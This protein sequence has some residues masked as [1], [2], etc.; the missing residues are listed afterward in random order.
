M[1]NFFN[2]RYHVTPAATGGFS[3]PAKLRFGKARLSQSITGETQQPPNRHQ[4]EAAGYLLFNNSSFTY[5]VFQ[6]ADVRVLEMADGDVVRR[7]DWLY[8]NRRPLHRVPAAPG[9]TRCPHPLGS[10]VPV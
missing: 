8:R 4:E 9:D 2:P 6:V 3:C 5:A 7:L 10:A 1:K